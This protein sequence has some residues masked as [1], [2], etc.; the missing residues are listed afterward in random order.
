MAAT[1]FAVLAEDERSVEGRL[2]ADGRA[3]IALDDLPAALGWELRPEG[4]CRGDVCVPVRDRT[5]LE[6][7]GAVDLVAVGAALDRP[8]VV[9]AEAGVVAFGAHRAERRRGVAE[10]EAPPFTLPDLEGNPRSL[11][12]WH[13]KRKLLIAFASW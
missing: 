10:H 2:D 12:E 6:V 7:D 13:T 9:D 1:T 4:L 11:A 3:L 5:G 8:V